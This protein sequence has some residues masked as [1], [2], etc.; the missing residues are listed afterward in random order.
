MGDIKTCYPGRASILPGTWIGTM[1]PQSG[2]WFGDKNL[3]PV[4][5]S[6]RARHTGRPAEQVT[7]VSSGY[8]Q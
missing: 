7:D 1:D 8:V 2:A 4:N 5:E 6:C 3:L